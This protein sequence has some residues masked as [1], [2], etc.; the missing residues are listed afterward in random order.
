MCAHQPRQRVRRGNTPPCHLPPRVRGGWWRRSAHHYPRRSAH[1]AYP[2]D[3]PAND[4]E[5]PHNPVFR[6]RNAF[7]RSCFCA[8]VLSM[9]SAPLSARWVQPRCLGA[10]AHLS[11][12]LLCVLDVWEPVF[13][14]AWCLCRPRALAPCRARAFLWRGRLWPLCAG[15]A[16]L[17][18]AGRALGNAQ[19]GG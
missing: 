2:L 17:V 5:P 9:F 16:G 1:R 19:L 3:V 12:H 13:L 8:P 7:T 11:D 4:L 15:A 10:C 14:W 18:R 6:P